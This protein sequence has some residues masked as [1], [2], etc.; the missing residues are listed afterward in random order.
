M[1]ADADYPFLILPPGIA[2][3][4]GVEQPRGGGAQNPG[5]ARQIERLDPAFRELQRALDGRQAAISSNALGAS[6]A[7][8]TLMWGVS[9]ITASP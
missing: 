2:T 4:V 8:S 3:S 7:T 9:W 1:A 5:K 6:T